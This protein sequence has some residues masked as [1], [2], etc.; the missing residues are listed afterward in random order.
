MGV[1]KKIEVWGTVQLQVPRSFAKTS[2]H[3]NLETSML[4][5]IIWVDYRALY[6]GSK[7]SNT[8]LRTGLY[9]YPG[10]KI[11]KQRVNQTTSAVKRLNNT[12]LFPY[13]N[14]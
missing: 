14:T 9:I 13:E 10:V 1:F 12:F 2:I 3:E 11:I 5:L 6:E 7:C 8:Y 4:K